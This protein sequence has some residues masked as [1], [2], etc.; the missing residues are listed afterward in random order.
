MKTIKNIST[1]TRKASFMKEMTRLSQLI[2]PN[3]VKMYG[4]VDEGKDIV[5][6]LCLSH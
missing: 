1:S 4:I 3:I 6:K 5:L 2:H